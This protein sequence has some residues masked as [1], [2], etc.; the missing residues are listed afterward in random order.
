MEPTDLTIEILK[1]IRD[2]VRA[3]HGRFDQMD[4][5]I[6]QTNERIDAV[7]AELRADISALRDQQV[8]TEVHLATELVAN[9]AA[10]RALRDDLKDIGVRTRLED[11]E[12]R[13][14]AL[15]K[16]GR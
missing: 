13:L 10:L 1:N 8:R 2:E 7:R 16:R 15:E 6:D 11:H 4:R 3:T 14:D 12:R 5:R 9:T